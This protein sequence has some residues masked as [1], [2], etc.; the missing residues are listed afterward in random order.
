LQDPVVLEASQ[1]SIDLKAN[2]GT[3]SLLTSPK[4][5][6]AVSVSMQGSVRAQYVDDDTGQV[7]ISKVDYAQ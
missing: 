3:M 1:A 7:T 4:D 5:G 6:V 2:G